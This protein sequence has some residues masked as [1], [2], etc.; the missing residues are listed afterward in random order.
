MERI[1]RLE[2]RLKYAAHTAAPRRRFTRR[3]SSLSARERG[4]ELA[5]VRFRAF[6]GVC[7]RYLEATGTKRVQRLPRA[8][9]FHPTH[10]TAAMAP[11]T[12][13]PAQRIQPRVQPVGTPRDQTTPSTSLLPSRFSTG[14]RDPR[15]GGLPAPIPASTRTAHRNAGHSM[16]HRQGALD[17]KIL[18]PS[19]T[20]TG[21]PGDAHEPRNRPAYPATRTLHRRWRVAGGRTTPGR[22]WHRGWAA[23]LCGF[24]A[25]TLPPHPWPGNRRTSPQLQELH[26]SI[27]VGYDVAPGVSLCLRYQ[28]L[29]DIG[30]SGTVAKSSVGVLVTGSKKYRRHI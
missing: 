5:C 11:L 19:A 16:E 12:I 22:G 20:Q 10:R 2:H 8:D 4:C 15:E 1:R 29:G 23:R 30:T 17:L 24:R 21:C 27:A 7:R 14:T 6:L 28:H 3:S 13:A 26:P 18:L 25:R 9:T